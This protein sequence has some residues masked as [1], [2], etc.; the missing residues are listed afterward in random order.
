MIDVSC[1]PDITFETK[2]TTELKFFSPLIIETLSS[3]ETAWD[4]DTEY[5]PLLE[6]EKISCADDINE[7]IA[8]YV[9][10]GEEN[11]GLM[12]YYDSDSPVNE[13]VVSAFP[14]VEAKDGKLMGVLTSKV[15]GELTA[16]ELE[17][18]RD[19]WS[20]QESDGY[21]EGW[22]QRDIDT[23]EFGEINVHF[24]NDGMDWNIKMEE[25]MDAP[26][27]AQSLEIS[28]ITM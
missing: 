26:D 22:E 21:G 7:F 23:D 17:E 1:Q 4:R 5:E 15:C 3:Y 6:C 2:P 10:D 28:G 19:W 14:S 13:K 11:R 20:G 18:L 24:W 27:E 16:T 9:C 25:E 8:G 12:A